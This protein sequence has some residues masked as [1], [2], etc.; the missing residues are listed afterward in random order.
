[1]RY[2]CKVC[3]QL[4]TDGNHWCPEPHCPAEAMT[5]VLNDGQTVSDMRVTKLIRVMPTATLYLA[6]RGGR[7]VFI[8]MAHADPECIETL[9]READ[10]LSS[11]RSVIT[12]YDLGLPFL[13]PG[14][15]ESRGIAGESRRYSKITIQ[16]ELKY[17]EVLD[18]IRGD[19]LSDVLLRNP[20]PWLVHV[21]WIF[22]SLVRT[23]D[24]L[25]Q[26]QLGWHLNL[27]PETI[28]IRQDPDGFWRAVIID[29]G[30]A[31]VIGSTNS[32]SDGTVS[33]T[34][35]TAGSAQTISEVSFSTWLTRF[36]KAAYIAPELINTST[37]HPTL[38][39]SADPRVDAY[40]AGMIL[41]EMLAGHAPFEFVLSKREEILEAVKRDNF[42]LDRRDLHPS[43]TRLAL[44]AT[45][46][47]P[48]LR[49]DFAAMLKIYEASAQSDQVSLF[50]KLPRER[51]RTAR[52]LA[53]IRLSPNRIAIILVI[54]VTL[55]LLLL[56][57][58][59]LTN[60]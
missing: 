46:R 2:A 27:N 36:G 53:A 29:L 4:S 52:A 6:E 47:R 22:H 13:L 8:K 21:G 18:F 7:P 42:H 48:E 14:A 37:A 43:I 26:K 10:I 9:K 33:R 49:P 56:F 35:S 54:V 3:Q 15:I 25:H 30:V 55:V 19:F 39:G 41:Y 60:R 58:T 44:E 24:F 50:Q 45:A 28:L 17:Y 16:N 38:T 59:A 23:L 32:S 20:Q 11:V 5:V 40:G 12:K 57:V 51:T 34:L 31:A 1:M